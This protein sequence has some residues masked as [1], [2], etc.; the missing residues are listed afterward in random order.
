MT[1]RTLEGW[2]EFAKTTQERLAPIRQGIVEGPIKLTRIVR[3]VQ[4]TR[5]QDINGRILNTTRA[6]TR[7][8]VHSAIQHASNAARQE[9]F[10]ENADYLKGV[11]WVSTLD[12]Y[13]PCCAPLDGKLFPVNEGKRPPI[14]TNCLPADSLV[15]STGIYSLASK[16]WHE[17]D[18][19]VIKTA[20]ETISLRQTSPILTDSGWFL[21]AKS[22]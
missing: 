19:V 12:S 5:Q 6:Q 4:G 14:H 16:R 22:M 3:R 17:G 20:S 7:A 10:T 1:G 9:V 13:V 18:M 2:F 21:L 11:Q 8:A 15:S